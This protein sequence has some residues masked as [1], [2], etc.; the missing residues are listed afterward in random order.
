[1]TSKLKAKLKELPNLPGVYFHK[2]KANQI[3]Y[4]GKAANLKNRVR[5]Y[6]IKSA[7]RDSKTEALIQE[8]YDT[9]WMTVAS[10]MDALFLEAEMIKRYKPKY[11]ILLQD[12]RSLAYVRIDPKSDSPT[13]TLTRNPLDDQAI[14][15][16]PYYSSINLRNALRVL[17]PIF[18]YATVKARTS[19]RVS[20]HY[21]LGLDPG[22]EE[23]RT[24]LSEYRNNLK[25]LGRVLKGQRNDIIKNLTVQM[26]RYAK[27]LNFEEASKLRNKIRALRNLD[28]QIIFSTNEFMD[29]SKDHALNELKELF[30]LDQVP[31]RIEGYDISHMQGTDVV[32]SMVVF[33]N[34]V[35]DRTAYRKF[36]L[37][38]DQNNDFFNINETIARRLSAQNVKSNPLP[39]LVIIDGG[40][41][42]LDAALN[43]LNATDYQLKIVGLAKREEQIVI[44]K[45]R[46][47]L[48]INEDYL[49]SLKGF[50]AES[51]NFILL[52]L[53]HSTNLIKLFQRIRDES[54]R[55]AV[56]YHS[57]LKRK[58]QTSSILDNISGIGPKTKKLILKEVGS[59]NNL[60]ESDI[61]RLRNVIGEK[62]SE[63]L[64]KALFTEKRSK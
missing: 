11:N 6:F 44:D 47:N 22:L 35:S 13:V 57:S 38:F 33:I 25:Q 45:N 1:M 24:T 50:K 26:D 43:A 63:L 42:Q 41:G 56:S 37:K 15:Y 36:K 60:K 14:Y 30:K 16:G 29:I 17:R 18:P 20:L 5:Q 48:T 7:N 2:D 58:R 28:K 21:H 31:K 23:G 34:G 12:D 27:Q 53:P 51:D 62:R 54:H 59:V 4:V 10:E 9:D 8:I 40:K 49:K 32:A 46:S 52:N 39:D 19:Q 64:K 61:L 3:I 55:F